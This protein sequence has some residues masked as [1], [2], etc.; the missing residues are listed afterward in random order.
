MNKLTFKDSMS[1]CHKIVT[2]A[3][4]KR[5]IMDTSTLTPNVHG[6]GIIPKQVTV[7]MV[8]FGNRDQNFEFKANSSSKF[9]GVVAVTQPLTTILYKVL[10]RVFLKYNI[11]QQ[12]LLKWIMFGLSIVL[13]FVLAKVYIQLAK[14]KVAKRVSPNAKRYIAKFTYWKKRDYSNWFMIL[15]I[16][17]IFYFFLK[18]TNGTE[19]I[20][21]VPITILAHLLF[22]FWLGMAPVDQN[23]NRKR[24]QL[25]SIE[26]I[27]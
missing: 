24:M 22:V 18:S 11:H 16:A 13:A 9:L 20:L 6:F 14:K 21:L 15:L 8:E 26:E 17:I 4:G 3:N 25:V 5:Y 27:Q 19:G 2:D 12:V 1:T 10:E 7:E 23:Y